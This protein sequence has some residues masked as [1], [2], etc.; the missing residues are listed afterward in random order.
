ML[1]HDHVTHDARLTLAVLDGAAAAGA[2]VLNHVEVVGL[3]H[4]RRA[5]HRRRRRRPSGRRDAID[6]RA[7][8]VVNA[9]GPWIDRVRQMER[10][11][12][13]TTVQLSRGTHLVLGGRRRLA[14]GDHGHARTTAGWRSR[15]PFQDGLLLGTTDHPYDGDPADVA[16]DPADE[17]QI[18]AEA[19]LSL[20]AAAIDPARIRQRFAGLRVLPVAAGPTSE[21]PREVVLTTGPGGMV[22]IA[23]GKL[24]TWRRIGLQAA[25]L[26][27][28]ALGLAALDTGRGRCRRP[29]HPDAA[30]SEVLRARFPLV[31]EAVVAHLVHGHGAAAGVILQRPWPTRR[32]SRRSR[33]RAPDIGA[34]VLH[35]RDREWAV[36]VDDVVRRTGLAPRGRRRCGARERIATL[37]GEGAMSRPLICAHRGASADHAD[38]SAA[39]FEAAIAAGADL[40]ETDIRRGRD[41]SLVLAHDPIGDDEEPMELRVLLELAR[42][43]VG[44]DLELKESGLERELL[45]LLEPEHREGLIMTS[46]LPVVIAEFRRLDASLD[47]G[48]LVEE[49]PGGEAIG[50]LTAVRACGA[51]FLAPDI[52]L[53]GPEARRAAARPRPGPVGVDGQ[54]RGDHRQAGRR[55]RYRDHH[56]RRSG[57]RAIDHR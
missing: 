3:Q 21:A 50:L 5:G 43:R 40:V 34:Q 26:A 49:E 41:G 45:E 23:G 52:A 31:D 25:G 39:A 44:L 16:P 7:R 53:L 15:C 30:A 28:A 1:Y 42:G 46:F 10:P 32:C 29:S 24:T 18:L 55:R 8:V 36:S 47:L 4:A 51:D 13:G 20:T 19:G 2:L 38:N 11:G 9:S 27:S 33:C 17:Q 54:R 37:L 22:S 12:A 48:L 56:D 14:G 57:A 35:A 6:V